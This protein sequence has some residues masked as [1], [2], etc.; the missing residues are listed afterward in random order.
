M[1]NQKGMAQHPRT[2]NS[3]E[4]L[5]PLGLGGKERKQI[6][7][8]RREAMAVGGSC[9]AGAVIFRTER[10]PTPGNSTGRSRRNKYPNFSLLPTSVSYEGPPW[11][12][13]NQPQEDEGALRG[14]PPGCRREGGGVWVSSGKCKI[15]SLGTD[16]REDRL[17]PP[18]PRRLSTE[19]AKA[20]WRVNRTH[21]L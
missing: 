14:Q 11:A 6:W 12:K 17:R 3:E 5:L 8:P 21:C 10:Q 18:P 9:L 20:L 7:N 15:P 2:R 4:S 1:G 16:Q 13:A 19:R